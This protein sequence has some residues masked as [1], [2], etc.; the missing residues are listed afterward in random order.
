MKTVLMNCEKELTIC[1]GTR[2]PPIQFQF[3]FS[4]VL[5]LVSPPDV[6]DSFFTWTNF[7]RWVKTL[8]GAAGF[9]QNIRNF[10]IDA[11]SGV[12][13]ERATRHMVDHELYP[14]KF[15]IGQE[16][17]DRKVCT[18]FGKSFSQW[19]WNVTSRILRAKHDHLADD[20]N[21]PPN[22]FSGLN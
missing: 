14:D 5:I 1:F 2:N 15:N 13:A 19:L 18:R 8:D 21:K 11:V 17:Y 9:L 12:S 6:L 7:R 16:F 10:D 22:P 3:L 4:T 20:P